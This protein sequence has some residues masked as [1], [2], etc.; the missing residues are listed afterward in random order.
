MEDFLRPGN[1]SLKNSRLSQNPQ[2]NA[3]SEVIKTIVLECFLPTV[4]FF[5]QRFY[6][7]VII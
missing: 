4:Q 1:N 5:L 2:I 3:F 6:G 7:V